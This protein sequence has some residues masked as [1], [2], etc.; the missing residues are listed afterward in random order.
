MTKTLVCNTMG[1]LIDVP[2]HAF[3]TICAEPPFTTPDSME[4]RAA[5][6]SHVLLNIVRRVYE[7]GIAARLVRTILE[8]ER[9]VTQQFRNVP[10]ELAYLQRLLHCALRDEEARTEDELCR[11]LVAESENIKSILD[12]VQEEVRR[13]GIT[14]WGAALEVVG[15]VYAFGTE[16]ELTR[17][18]ALKVVQDAM[19]T[20]LFLRV[21]VE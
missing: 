6:I 16:D 10:R 13:A 11:D 4:K 18:A 3:V 9:R 2:T 21:K 14:R 20:R 1:L 8:V 17:L 12:I 5:E 19:A 7:T 15:L